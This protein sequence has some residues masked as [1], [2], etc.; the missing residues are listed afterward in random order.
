MVQ[1]NAA[2]WECTEHSTGY[3]TLGRSAKKKNSIYN[4]QVNQQWKLSLVA[5][6][7]ELVHVQSFY[8]VTTVQVN[9]LTG[10]L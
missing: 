5:A 4:Q 10:D 2:C 9:M 7:I 6:L 3:L 8:Q 1:G